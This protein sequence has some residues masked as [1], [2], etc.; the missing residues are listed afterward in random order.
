[1]YNLRVCVRNRVTLQRIHHLHAVVAPHVALAAV[2]RHQ[3]TC[4]ANLRHLWIHREPHVSAGFCVWGQELFEEAGRIDI[5]A[6][7]NRKARLVLWERLHRSR[8]HGVHPHLSVHA[9]VV[10]LLGVQGQTRGAVWAVVF[11]ALKHS[12]IWR[13]QGVWTKLGRFGRQQVQVIQQTLHDVVWAV[14]THRSSHL[15]QAG[16]GGRYLWPCR[17]SIDHVS[18][19]LS[20]VIVLRRERRPPSAQCAGVRVGSPPDGAPGFKVLVTVGVWASQPVGVL[21]TW[22]AGSA[23]HPF[24]HC[25][26]GIEKY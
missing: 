8:G 5:L 2:R 20:E 21:R 15:G 4:P 26:L 19:N 13:M 10:V 1:M 3:T 14:L 16:Q 11:Y 23:F 22:A 25:Q 6:L 18:L 7:V 9:L 17:S 24:L 12:D